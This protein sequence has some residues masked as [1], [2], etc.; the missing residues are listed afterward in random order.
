MYGGG[1]LL[2]VLA[3]S[4]RQTEAKI[5]SGSTRDASSVRDAFREVKGNALL[6]SYFLPH[7]GAENHLS[8]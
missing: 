7:F 6:D 8:F 3:G 1:E 2:A 5:R 4:I